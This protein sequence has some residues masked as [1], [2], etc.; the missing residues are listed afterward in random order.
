MLIWYHVVLIFG[1]QGLIVRRDV[2]IVIWEL[3]FAEVFEE[4]GVSGAVEVDICV[5]GVFGLIEGLACFI[6]PD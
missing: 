5:A 1:I 6:M 4:V 2:D 3:V